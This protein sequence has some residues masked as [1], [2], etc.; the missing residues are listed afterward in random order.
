M[1][2]LAYSDQLT[3]LAN[4][5]LFMDRLE[6]H[7]KLLGRRSNETLSIVMLLDLDNFKLINDTYGHLLG[8]QLLSAVAR[9]VSEFARKSDTLARLGGDE[10]V[11]L[12]EKVESLHYAGRIADRLIEHLSEPYLLNDKK[13][14]VKVSMG[15]VVLDPG[16]H[17]TQDQV[18]HDADVAL[19]RA[20][21]QGRACWVLF[22]QQMDAMIK[23]GRQLQAELKTAIVE[24]KLELYYQPIMDAGE[25]QLC[26]FES[27]ARWRR[28]NGEWVSPIEFI[29]LAEENGMI[30]DVGLWG[31]ETACQQIA[32]WNETHPGVEYYVSV[33]IAS[34]SFG[35]ER[36]ARCISECF[37]RYGVRR[38]QLK[39]ELTERILLGDTDNM[40]DK[41]HKLIE[42]GCE[43]MIDDFGT[44]YSS[45]SY[46]HLL[47]V[48]AMKIDRSFV[49][50]LDQSESSLSV[51]KTIIALARSLDLGIVAEGV[52]TERQAEQLAI[53]G[54][55]ELQGYFFG[56]PVPES[57]A[58]HYFVPEKK[59]EIINQCG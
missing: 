51:V 16:N 33:N 25:R 40:L 2:N 19:Y 17:L 34:D 27:L 13:V 43:V 22:D 26:G 58:E 11:M 9:R 53:L 29:A 6:H 30:A 57:E 55:T 10:F 38:G 44:G 3:G 47:P 52:E 35:D 21:R 59:V 12:F 1:R 7:L 28:D 48:G 14:E 37:Q 4:R 54:A 50:N 23:R 41:L 20:K 5:A 36:F 39:L 24:N 46:L 56:R 8:D 45:L 49:L 31:I 32:R 15:V 42:L 18:L